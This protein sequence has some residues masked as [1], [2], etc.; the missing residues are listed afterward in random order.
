MDAPGFEELLELASSRFYRWQHK[1][2]RPE[3]DRRIKEV[4]TLDMRANGRAALCIEIYREL[5]QREVRKRITIYRNVAGEFPGSDM[6]SPSRLETLRKLIMTNVEAAVA[7]LKDRIEM[8]AHAAGDL[9]PPPQQSA[10]TG[11]A[12]NILDVVNDEL[13]VLEAEGRLKWHSRRNTAPGTPINA[14]KS[15]ELPTPNVRKRRGRPSIPDERKAAALNAKNTGK[16]NKDAAT[17][18]YNTKFPTPQ[19]VKNVSSILKHYQ[20][21]LRKPPHTS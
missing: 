19:Q 8:S 5:L 9:L 13:R 11:L 7:G 16:P 3:R 18:L 20:A 10:Y 4:G 6:F 2:L 21:R 12:S 17:L 1:V 14:E 15:P